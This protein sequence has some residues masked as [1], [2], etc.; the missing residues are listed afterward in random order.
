M[1]PIIENLLDIAIKRQPRRLAYESTYSHDNLRIWLKNILPCWEIVIPTFGKDQSSAALSNWPSNNIRDDVK[2]WLEEKNINNVDDL[3]DG[4]CEP[5]AFYLSSKIKTCVEEGKFHSIMTCYQSINTELDI[6]EPRNA[7]KLVYESFVRQEKKSPSFWGPEIVGSYKNYLFGHELAKARI[8]EAVNIRYVHILPLYVL[9]YIF[10][11]DE[12]S[13]RELENHEVETA[14]YSLHVVG[15]IFDPERD[16][17]IIA[18][19]NGALIP[20][21]NMEFLSMPLKTRRASDSTRVS[22]YDLDCRKRGSSG[23]SK[24]SGKKVRK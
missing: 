3:I 9:N 8:L 10:S 7:A 12:L 5:L 1:E 17:V 6:L 24:S 14:Q 20:G 18:D 19:S 15:L 11:D 21:S 4:S 16:R 2:V 23:V 13:D 22:R